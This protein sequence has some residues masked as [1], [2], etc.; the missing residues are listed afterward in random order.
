MVNCT[1]L[2][3]FDN[4]CGDQGVAA[5]VRVAQV[6]GALPRLEQ[7]VLNSNSVG[8]AGFRTLTEALDEGSAW[9]SL[10]VLCIDCNP[11]SLTESVAD[12]LIAAGRRRGVRVDCY[13][14]GKRGAAA[15][16]RPEPAAADRLEVCV[17]P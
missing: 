16:Q 14:P 2:G 7:I 11:A 12:P 17:S 5:M 13:P 6:N 4:Q 9:P 15:A 1:I 3:L 10:K 8:H